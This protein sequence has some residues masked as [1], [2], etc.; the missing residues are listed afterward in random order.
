[1]DSTEFFVADSFAPVVSL[2]PLNAADHT[3][4]LQAVYRATPA[5][6][7]MYHLPSSPAGQAKIDLENVA[8]TPGRTMMGIAR[9]VDADRAESGLEMVGVVDFRMHWPD[10]NMVYVG[11]MMVAEGYQRQGIATAAWRVL[12][13]WLAQS[14]Q[15]SLARVGVEQF[16]PGALQFFQQLGF[17]LTGETSRVQSGKR[18][19]RLLYMDYPLADEL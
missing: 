19:V 11:M 2:F 18:W 7:Q 16:N 1:M 14:A 12:A 4:V 3:E 8:S 17:Q 9:R 15:M 6:W 13:P 5:Y 10:P